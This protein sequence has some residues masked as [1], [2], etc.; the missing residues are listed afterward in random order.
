[1]GP[2]DQRAISARDGPATK[3]ALHGS[4]ELDAS[5]ITIRNLTSNEGG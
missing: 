3:T 4:V 1:M 2:T 5:H